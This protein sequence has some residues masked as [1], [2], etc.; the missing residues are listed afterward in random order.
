M[1]NDQYIPRCCGRCIQKYIE[2]S[3]TS[4]ISDTILRHP[5]EKGALKVTYDKDTK[6]A[7]TIFVAEQKKP[8]NENAP[9]GPATKA[10]GAVFNAAK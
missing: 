5:D 7:T 2:N 8:A 10:T 6:Q 1:C 9:G 4:D 3:I